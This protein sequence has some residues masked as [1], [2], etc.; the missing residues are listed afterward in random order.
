MLSFERFHLGDL[1]LVMGEDQIQS[2]AVDIV[3]LAEIFLGDGGI[4]DMPAGPPPAP[5]G[6]PGIF[7]VFPG[8]PER[9]V[10]R[11]ML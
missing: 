5:R 6:V 10:V 7:P 3:L 11:I 9:K 2:A 8:L 4:F 1:C